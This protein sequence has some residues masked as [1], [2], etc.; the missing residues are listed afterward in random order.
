MQKRQHHSRR[1]MPPEVA[2]GPRTPR[3]DLCF[4]P[5]SISQLLPFTWPTAATTCQGC[6]QSIFQGD[7]AFAAVLTYPHHFMLCHHCGEALALDMGLIE[8]YQSPW[9][10]S[11]A[12]GSARLPI[13]Q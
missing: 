4:D 12:A 10:P 1:P 7:T 13:D 3:G 9:N 11:L 5:D 8:L 2:P 6:D